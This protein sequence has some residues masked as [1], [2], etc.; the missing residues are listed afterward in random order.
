MISHLNMHRLS[1][2]SLWWHSKYHI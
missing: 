2:L 1:E